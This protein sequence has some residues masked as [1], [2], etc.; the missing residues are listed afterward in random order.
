MVPVSSIQVLNEANPYESWGRHP[1]ARSRLLP[2]IESS[3]ALGGVLVAGAPAS[4]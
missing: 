1:R 2:M 3:A 4:R